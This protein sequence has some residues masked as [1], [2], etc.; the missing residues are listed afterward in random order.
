[1]RDLEVAMSAYESAF[2]LFKIGP[3]DFLSPKNELVTYIEI[4]PQAFELIQPLNSDSI[5]Y[6]FLHERGEGLHHIAYRTKNLTSIVEHLT[7]DRGY[8]KVNCEMES[9]ILR[10]CTQWML[11]PPADIY[12]FVELL[13]FAEDL[14][15]TLLDV[16]RLENRSI[17][18]IINEVDKKALVIALASQPSEV[19]EK[20]L[21]NMSSRA[22][23]MVREDLKFLGHVD[24][25]SMNEA[26]DHVI[27][28]VKQLIQCGDICDAQIF[29]KD[30]AAK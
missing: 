27:T 25:I 14:E 17:Q 6:N 18:R 8:R 12:S 9:N 19:L 20:F 3:F 29:D 24:P 1:M 2:Q 28:I 13:Q 30:E 23:L 11:Q 22:A 5:Y 15:I 4:G 16:R 10:G 7:K 26:T 21:S